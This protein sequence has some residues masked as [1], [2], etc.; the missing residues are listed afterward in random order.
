MRV[1]K[2]A[3]T[4]SCYGREGSNKCELMLPAVF[5]KMKIKR[6]DL[7]AGK[8]WNI[9]Q[10]CWCFLCYTSKNIDQINSLFPC[11]T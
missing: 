5:S 11:E 3:E 4:V 1:N 8:E 6:C 7:D 9:Q 2:Q 10:P